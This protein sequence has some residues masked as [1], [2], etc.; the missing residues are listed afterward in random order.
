M[1]TSDKI[2]DHIVSL[3]KK[4]NSVK[5]DN[6]HAHF[7]S[8]LPIVKDYIKKKKIILYGGLAINMYLPKKDQFYDSQEIPDFDGFCTNPEGLS[9][10]L[11][12]KLKNHNFNYLMI[13]YAIHE[14]TFKLSWEFND[15][16]DLTKISN[17]FYSKLLKKAEIK[18]NIYLCPIHVLKGMSYF[19]MCIPM[20]SLFRWEKIYPRISLLEKHYPLHTKI[21]KYCQLVE[22]RRLPDHIH[23]IIKTVYNYILQL[24]IP[25]CDNVALNNMLDMHQKDFE[26]FDENIAY[27]SCLA[28]VD[29]KILGYILDLCNEANI[30]KKSTKVKTIKSNGF[31]PDETFVEIKYGKHRYKIFS[32]YSV[33]KHCYSTISVNN[34]KCCTSFFLIYNYYFRLFD[35]DNEIQSDK[36]RFVLKALLNN[37]SER[38]FTNEC[39]GSEKTITAVKMSRARRNAPA[40]FYKASIT[41]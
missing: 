28:S 25:F 3:N 12:K 6:K 24:D 4:H 26:T 10:Q 30:S 16:L 33:D 37:I 18:D 2:M 8:I 11:I 5:R 29:N 9:K 40:I 23:G 36:Y 41:K 22:D 14:G 1:E 39:Y 34:I 13:R 32:Y 20:S 27:I 17:A 38:D 7:D 15:V 31:V 35:C 19:E 21:T